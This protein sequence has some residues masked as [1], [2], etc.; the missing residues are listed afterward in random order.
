MGWK[1]DKAE[2]LRRVE[3]AE[4]RRAADKAASEKAAKANR[5]KIASWKKR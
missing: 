2:I 5:E 3:K 4:Q 1:D